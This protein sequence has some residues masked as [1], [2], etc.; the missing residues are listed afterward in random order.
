MTATMTGANMLAP[1]KIDIRATV[2]NYLRDRFPAL[3][4][5]PIDDATPLLTG[6][7]VDSLGILDLTAF[8]T[9]RLGIQ[10][11]DEDFEPGNFE[12]FGCLIALVERRRS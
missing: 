6:G 1:E 4:V 7:A 10:I 8:L 5:K 12:T 9:E 2:A 11:S 3:A